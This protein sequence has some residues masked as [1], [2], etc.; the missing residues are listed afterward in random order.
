MHH[1]IL[2]EMAEDTKGEIDSVLVLV[3]FSIADTKRMS[4]EFC[5][6]SVGFLVPHRKISSL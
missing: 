5:N 2:N 1:K 4:N 6:I 3:G